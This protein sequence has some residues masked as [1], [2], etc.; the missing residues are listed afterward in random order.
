MAR[1]T[2]ATKPKSKRNKAE[3]KEVAIRSKKKVD[4]VEKVIESIE[5][6]IATKEIKATLGDYIRLLQL[7]KELEQEQPREIEVT[8]VHPSEKEPVSET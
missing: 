8:W 7:R 5:A 2:A 4:I 1:K 6:K 3:G